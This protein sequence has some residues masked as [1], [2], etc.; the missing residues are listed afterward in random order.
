MNIASYKIQQCFLVL[1]SFA[2]TC[3]SVSAQSNEKLASVDLPEDLSSV[4]LKNLLNFDLVVNL[5]GRKDQKLSEAASAVYVLSNDEIRRSG[6]RHVADAL[7]LV[8]GVNVTRITSNKWAI[9][10]RGFNQLFANKLLVLIDG[11][12]VFSPTT[13]GV[14]WESNELDLADVD[15]IEV[16]RGPGAV[17]WGSIAVNGVINVITKHSKETLGGNISSGAGTHERAFGRARYGGTFGNDTTYRIYSLANNRTENR[18]YQS[19][20]E[21][22]DE[23]QSYALGYRVD[24]QLNSKDSLTL[25]GDLSY[26]SDFFNPTP[27]SLSAPFVDPINFTGDGEYKNIRQL[28]K[29]TRSESNDSIFDTQLS[30]VHKDRET[31]LLSFVYDSLTLD[32][33]HRYKLS[34]NHDLVYGGA[35]RFFYN[36]TDDTEAQQV[37]PLKRSTNLVSGFIQDE[38]KIIPNKLRLILGSKFEYTEQVDFAI[39]PNVRTI[40]DVNNNT[41]VWAAVSG[42]QATPALFFEDSRIPVAAFPATTGPFPVVLEVVGNRDLTSE[43]LIAYELGLRNS[44]SKNWSIDLATFY[45]KYDNIFSSETGDIELGHSRLG[46]QT[47]LILPLNLS[48]GLAGDTY[49]FELATEWRILSNWKTVLAYSYIDQNI[50]LGDSTDT[51]NRDLINGGTSHNQVS[52]RNSYDLTEDW[53]FD[54]NLRYMDSIAYSDTPSYISLDLRAA[55]K[56]TNEIEFSIVGQNLLDNAHLENKG[57]LFTPP[58]TEIERGVYAALSVDF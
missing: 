56:L 25:S 42:A 18:L 37:F 54:A 30:Y 5:P 52:L 16:V 26:Q 47:A 7:R 3:S 10:I 55:W 15:R 33:Q 48:N 24:S 20:A 1:L 43:K 13:N 22:Q 28:A 4:D 53:L 27:P 19:D 8:P 14:Y 57:N 9:S 35:Y 21:S 11:V 46:D 45:N 23:W 36:T 17:L 34:E 31:K 39:M 58:P 49:G 32:A 50:S 6:V 29:W 38:I 40:W 12:S 41:S 2:F 51:A 44:I